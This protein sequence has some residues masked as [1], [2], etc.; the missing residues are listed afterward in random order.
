MNQSLTTIS[1]I[2]ALTLVLLGSAPE[3]NGKKFNKCSLAKELKRQGFPRNELADW[4][5]LVLSES[6]GNTA[7]INKNRNGSKDYGLFQIN[8]RYWCGPKKDCGV[9]CSAL[10]KDDIGVASKCA[11]LI[12][13]R[14]KFQA[15]YGWKAKC[16][17]GK[18]NRKTY[19]NGCGV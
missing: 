8:D 2:L 11:K 17:G 10:L 18:I 13:K 1:A 6:S 7:A 3:V 16:Q 5:C 19:L 14:H 12:Y 15:W 4:T 9:S